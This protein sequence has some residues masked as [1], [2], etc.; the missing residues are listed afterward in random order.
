[1]LNRHFAGDA[2]AFHAPRT[3][4]WFLTARE[5][6]PVE[7]DA[8]DPTSPSAAHLP[9]GPHGATWRRWL[10]EMQML[11]HE[12]PV[13]A[14]R[15]AADARRSPASGVGR[16]N[17]AR[18]VPAPRMAIHAAPSRAGDVASGI[19]RLP[20]RVDRLPA[21]FGALPRDGDAMVVLATRRRMRSRDWLSPSLAALERGDLDS[22]RSSRSTARASLRV[23]A[24]SWWRRMRA[25]S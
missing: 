2:V 18:T 1:M 4:A 3:D 25:R 15:E 5:S 12:H 13:N 23:G 8:L 21:S 22:S 20:P 19:A 24:P 9:R 7:T 10:S 17:A 11:L 16:R 14:A 6:V